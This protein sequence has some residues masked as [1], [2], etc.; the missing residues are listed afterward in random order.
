[1][2]Q[3]AFFTQHSATSSSLGGHSAFEK[4]TEGSPSASS[5]CPV[6]HAS[7]ANRAQS[8][9][10]SVA[11]YPVDHASSSRSSSA[12][13]AAPAQCPVQHSNSNEALDSRDPPPRPH[14][15]A[16]TFADY[17]SPH[18]AHGIFRS[19]ATPRGTGSIRL[20]NSSTTRWAARDFQ[21]RKARSTRWCRSTTS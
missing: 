1:M 19:I 8:S 17:R 18:G 15:G 10:R 6:D 2:G 13:A 4:R 11:N 16:H 20:R 9:S 21:F 12:A 5:P 7:L 3:I 14:V